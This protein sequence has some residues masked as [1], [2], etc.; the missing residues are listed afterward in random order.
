MDPKYKA[1]LKEPRFWFTLIATGITILIAHGVIK[2]SSQ[3][4]IYA[5]CAL[6]FMSALGIVSLA[7]WT[8]GRQVWTQEQREANGLPRVPPPPPSSSS[9]PAPTEPPK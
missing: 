9:P 3:G 1:M 2:P 5:Q 4:F 8:P 7:A 6:D